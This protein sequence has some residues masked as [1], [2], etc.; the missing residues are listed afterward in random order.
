MKLNVNWKRTFLVCADIAI[1]G[2]LF[3]ALTAWHRPVQE[4]SVCTKVVIDIQDEATNGFINTQEI[5]RRLQTAKRYPLEKPMRYI[6]ARKIEE[7]LKASPFV[8]TAECYKTQDGHVHITI[9]QRMPIIRIKAA[10]GEDYY[11]DDNDCIM[12]NSQYTSDLIIAT[13]NIN[14]WF[15]TNYISPLSKTLNGNQLW[16]NQIEQINVLSDGSVEMIP[17][18]PTA[19]S[20]L[21][22]V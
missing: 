16:R 2:Y 14:K 20:S 22:R 19:A 13:G 21:C 11:I 3:M 7:T 15:A 4:S 17:R 12:P 1:G 10:N 18:C 8:Q 9:T 6:D 5:K